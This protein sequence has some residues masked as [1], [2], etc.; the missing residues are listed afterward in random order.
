MLESELASQEVTQESPAPK[1]QRGKKATRPAAKA[2]VKA[3]EEEVIPEID[4]DLP[5]GST[6]TD[7]T[8]EDIEDDASETEAEAEDETPESE[9]D[10]PETDPESEDDTDTESNEDEDTD[11]EA[12][13]DEEVS[14]EKLPKSWQRSVKKLRSEAQSLRERLKAESARQAPTPDSPLADVVTEQ[15]LA[16]ALSNAKRVRQLFG[17]LTDDDYTHDQNGTPI[18][19]VTQ[20]NQSFTYTQEQIQ[21]MLA[22]SEQVL[23]PEVVLER[24][25][26][27]ATRNEVNPLETAEAIVPGIV[28]NKDSDASQWMQRV[29]QSVPGLR[30][31]PDFEVLLAHAH[32]DF[33]RQQ[34]TQPTKT[35]PKGKVKWVRYELDKD[36]KVI[37][38]KQ[39]AA[40]ANGSKP[41]AQAPSSPNGKRAPVAPVRP[42]GK[43]KARLDQALANR[44]TLNST[45]EIASMLAA[46]LA[47]G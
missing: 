14:L 28:T 46:E 33:Q 4:D 31:L 43:A 6:A 12:E 18:H 19:V 1:T 32:R 17:K 16:Q 38:P 34:E 27:L 47:A 40:A 3:K 2:P 9:E 41:A 45:E 35:H 22:R 21:R 7:S 36:G 37:P 23:D 30:K 20:G 10:T 25:Q 39:Q 8:D 42:E 13:S 5:T 26:Y 44:S 15:E 24:R 11:S 29:L